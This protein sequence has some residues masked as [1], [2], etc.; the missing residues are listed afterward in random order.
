MFIKMIAAVF[1]FSLGSAVGLAAPGGASTV[2]RYCQSGERSFFES[3]LEMRESDMV[4]S[5]K[6][7]GA[8]DGRFIIKRNSSAALDKSWLS[9][10]SY[11]TLSME[12]GVVF[13]G[14][15]HESGRITKTQI[16]L[17]TTEKDEQGTKHQ[18]MMLATEGRKAELLGAT[19]AC[20][21]PFSK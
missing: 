1:L 21:K 19:T 9:L 10:Y 6:G 4:L 12:T 3:T 8:G 15:V 14:E 16:F 18:V 7:L 20:S 2:H 17:F 5:V 11:L 13:N